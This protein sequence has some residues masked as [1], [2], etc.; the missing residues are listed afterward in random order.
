ML[1]YLISA[2]LRGDAVRFTVG[3]VQNPLNSLQLGVGEGEAVEDGE[4]LG[5]EDGLGVA[6]SVPGVDASEEFPGLHPEDKSIVARNPAIAEWIKSFGVIRKIIG[7]G[8]MRGQALRSLT[9]MR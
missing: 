2:G 5:D 3:P 7:P 8:R 6:S 4:G 1:T 9:R